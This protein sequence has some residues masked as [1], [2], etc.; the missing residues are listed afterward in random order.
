MANNQPAAK[1]TKS[2]KVTGNIL[3]AA[4]VAADADKGTRRLHAFK[5]HRPGSTIELDE[6]DAAQQAAI[7][8][9]DAPELVKK[10]KAA[11]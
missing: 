10:A 5:L 9:I 2:Y 7:G 11:K 4:P 1:A 8:H 3:A 6:T